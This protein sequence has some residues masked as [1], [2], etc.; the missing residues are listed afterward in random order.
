MNIRFQPQ[1]RIHALIYVDDITAE[2]K[3]TGN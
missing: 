3:T 2:V 1:M